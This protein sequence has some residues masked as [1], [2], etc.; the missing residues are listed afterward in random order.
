MAKP[1]KIPLIDRIIGGFS[2]SWA[3][4]R[5]SARTKWLR[6][7]G[8]KAEYEGASFSRR[9]AGWRRSG[10]DA[11]SELNSA[12][13]LALRGVAHEVVR[14]NPW[15]ASGVTKLANY[16]VGPGITFQVYRAG[17]IDK[18]LTDLARKHFDTT[19]CDA[20]G[21]HNLYGLQ[22]QAAR[23]IV[24]SGAVLQRRRWRRGSD[25]LPVPFQL[26][27]LEPDYINMMQ[28]Q[29]SAGGGARIQGIELD[30][31]GRRSGYWMYSGHPG[32]L[33]PGALDTKFVPATEIAHC[34]RAD[35]PEAMHG[36]TW[37]APVVVRIKDFGDF[38]D[39]QLVRQK[40]AACFAVFRV[41]DP[42]GDPPAAFDSNGQPLELE[43]NAYAVEPGMIEDIPSG[44]DIKFA[45]PPAVDGY[46]PFARV[47]REA[48]FT[49]I[50][51]PYE[52]GTGDLTKVSFISGRLGRLDF[53]RS[54]EGWQ[55]NML[56]PQLCEP[57]GRWF[58]EAAA[59][60]GE[61]IEGAEF[62][63]TPPRFPMMSPETEIPATRDAIRSGQQTISGAARERG[64]DPD[65]FLAE[66]AADAAKLD[67]LGLVF[68]SDPRKVTAVGNA[69][70]PLTPAAMSKRE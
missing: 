6:A 69:V 21:Q 45:S 18:R 46:E 1:P 54:I 37:F 35:R 68:D 29:P 49:G 51:L 44:T 40:I 62:R 59:M 52:I 24:E 10:R 17:V 47:S 43:P 39:A 15:A 61:D 31:I 66:W 57:A 30:A 55:Y 13:M 27:I 5:H 32:S 16:L 48:I 67:E 36:S 53:Q 11:N 65:V 2:P 42:A 38:E 3:L 56:I 63:W 7:S 14:N 33:L 50:G 58:L 41:G 70:A 12:V 23:T 9:T 34:Y 26:Q 28:S 22:Y 60:M 64:E 4:G 25:G 19:A 20:S 8:A